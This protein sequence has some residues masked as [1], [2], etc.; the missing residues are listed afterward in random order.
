M[1]AR[2]TAILFN[3]PLTWPAWKNI[4]EPK[5]IDSDG[6][7]GLRKK[8]QCLFFCLLFCLAVLQ[9]RWDFSTLT[10]DWT[11]VPCIGSTE[12]WPLDCQW[13]L[14]TVLVLKAD[15]KAPFAKEFNSASRRALAS[16]LLKILWG[17]VIVNYN[18]FGGSDKTFTWFKRQKMQAL[19]RKIFLFSIPHLTLPSCIHVTKSC[20]FFQSLGLGLHMELYTNSLFSDF[21]K[22][23]FTKMSA[24]F[25]SQEDMSVWFESIHG[26]WHIAHSRFSTNICWMKGVLHWV[27]VLHRVPRNPA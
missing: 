4:L 1:S 9:G 27:P 18:F 16:E 11:Y 10:R 19:L 22:C 2:L 20:V 14:L 6:G 23:L 21:F 17:E 24:S 15:S 25:M 13:R 7:A 5:T 26:A 12:F 3:P 8:S